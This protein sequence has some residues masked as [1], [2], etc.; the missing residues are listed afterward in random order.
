MLYYIIKNDSITN[1][2]KYI[3]HVVIKNYTT[4]WQ[5]FKDA[6]LSYTEITDPSNKLNFF[7]PEWTAEKTGIPVEDI[8][9]I[10]HMFG[11]TK[12]ASIEIGMHGTAHHSNG[13]VTS[14]LMTALLYNN[15]QY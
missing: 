8:I 3:D 12:P 6:F 11:S 15:R 9:K 1:E 5:K 13:D 4:G 2:Q 10:S 14:I 7:T